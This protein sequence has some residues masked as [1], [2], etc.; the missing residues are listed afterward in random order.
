MLGG[1]NWSF[2]GR[3]FTA[4]EVSI[5]VEMH[6][7]K[8][9]ASPPCEGT[10]LNT[11]VPNGWD[12]FAHCELGVP[13]PMTVFYLVLHLLMF[14]SNVRMYLSP[15]AEVKIELIS[16][17]TFLRRSCHGVVDCLPRNSLTFA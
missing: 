14:G 8:L 10:E 16:L 17:R 15:F 7:M 11:L 2:R 1:V 6:S 12:R 3:N 13:T 4:Y 5:F 9:F